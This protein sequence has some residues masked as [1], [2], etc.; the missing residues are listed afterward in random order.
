MNSSYSPNK[1]VEKEW[2]VTVS[3][4][5][6]RSVNMRGPCSVLHVLIYIHPCSCTRVWCRN[7]TWRR[8]EPSG[9]AG[10]TSSDI[11]LTVQEVELLAIA[12]NPYTVCC[13]PIYPLVRLTISLLL[14]CCSLP[15]QMRE[16]FESF[17]TIVRAGQWFVGRRLDVTCSKKF[18]W[19]RLQSL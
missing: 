10:A 17:S 2:A 9:A 12:G 5:R 19:V 8:Y 6:R 13:S 11:L 7:A 16:G 4:V 3:L 18:G 1:W 15:Y 14:V